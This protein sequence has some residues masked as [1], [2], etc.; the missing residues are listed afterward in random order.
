MEPFANHFTVETDHPSILEALR[1]GPF[2]RCVYRCS[3][4]VVDHQT[5]NMEFEGNI[6]VNFM[7]SGHSHDSSRTMRYDG[8]LATLKGNLTTDDPEIVIHDHTAGEP[9]ESIA[10]GARS[11]TGGDEAMLASLVQTI[12]GEGSALT[13]SVQ[14]ALEGHMMA[15][16]A[17]ESRV[18]GGA[19]IEMEEYRRAAHALATAT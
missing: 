6:N 12:R 11:V 7:L 14:E 9:V 3:N 18:R 16:A 17:E 5:V 1:T 2:W 8:T 10:L 4:D 13:T 15:Y 19:V